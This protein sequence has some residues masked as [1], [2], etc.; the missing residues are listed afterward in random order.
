MGNCDT[1]GKAPGKIPMPSFLG[2]NPGSSLVSA[3]CILSTEYPIVQRPEGEMAFLC[4]KSRDWILILVRN[5]FLTSFPL[6]RPSSGPHPSKMS[7]HTGLK[8]GEKF[9]LYNKCKGC[10]E[11]ILIIDTKCCHLWEHCKA[12]SKVKWDPYTAYKD[13]FIWR[14][15]LIC[16]PLLAHLILAKMTATPS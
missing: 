10:K 13:K 15:S 12:Q 2:E 3:S 1:Q 11:R 14:L 4:L 9:H 16:Q 7:G 8:I 6:L 5:H